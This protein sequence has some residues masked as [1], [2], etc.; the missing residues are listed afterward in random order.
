MAKGNFY[1]QGHFDRVHKVTD[2]GLFLDFIDEQI[3]QEKTVFTR[4]I[5]SEG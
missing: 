2:F 4:F 5:A 3:E 1:P